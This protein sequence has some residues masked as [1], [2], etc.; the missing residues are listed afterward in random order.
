[1]TIIHN[2]RGLAKVIGRLWGL[3]NAKQL[4]PEDQ[5]NRIARINNLLQQEA[6]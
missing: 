5:L 3:R 1:M 6:L 4:W 2:R